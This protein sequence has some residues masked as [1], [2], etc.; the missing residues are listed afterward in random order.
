M[1]SA[2]RHTKIPPQ[3]RNPSPKPPQDA[4]AAAQAADLRYVSDLE[5]GIR[6]LCAGKGFRY[7]GPNGKKV[8]APE[9]LRR[10]RSLVPPPAWRDVW[11]CTRR[12]GHVQATGRDARG[13]K[14]YRY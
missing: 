10:I 12:D 3:G 1:R 5:L 2:A 11:I 9:T 13:R 4:V 14:Q 6:R 8:R 7:V